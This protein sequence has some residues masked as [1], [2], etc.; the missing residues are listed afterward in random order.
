MVMMEERLEKTNDLNL[1]KSC[2]FKIIISIAANGGANY[3][4]YLIAI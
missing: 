3:T 1:L 4:V 2:S